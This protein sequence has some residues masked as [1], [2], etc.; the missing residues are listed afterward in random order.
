MKLAAIIVAA[1]SSRRMGFDKLLATLG[2]KAVLEHSIQAF[3]SCEDVEEIVVVCPKER[4]DA[5]DLES[6][7]SSGKK[8]RRVNGGR[9]RH[10][11]VAAGLSLLEDNADIDYIAVHDGARP[12]IANSQ[13]SIV[14]HD[15]QI[16]RCSASARQ[17]TET[18]KRANAEDVVIEAV[19]R[20]QLWLMETP[21]IF[22]ADLLKEAYQHVLSQGARVTDEVSALELIGCSTHLV[23]NPGPNPKITYPHDIVQAEKFL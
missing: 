14:F 21:Q 20:E 6:L 17:V 22:Q 19:D 23:P 11:S 3:L 4:F 8:I 2:S 7:T 9:D 5:L 15:A 16:Y 12:L 18:V 13:I 10:D 1:G